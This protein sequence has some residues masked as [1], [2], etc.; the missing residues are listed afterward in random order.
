M[1]T[2]A[3]DA[4][5]ALTAK[6]FAATITSAALDRDGEVV[7]PQGM[8]ATS[9]ERNPILLWNH[10]SNYPVGKCTGLKRESYGI[11]GE[12]EF[13]QRPDN[14][15]GQWFPAFAASLV[16][17]GIV[18]G[19]S[20]G[21]MNEQGGTRRATPQDKKQFGDSVHTVFSKW[22]LMEISL[23]PVQSNPDALVTAIRKGKV[24]STDATRWLG[25]KATERHR[26][27][28]FLPAAKP[29]SVAKNASIDYNAIVRREIARARGALR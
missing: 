22:S 8:N 4:Q 19:V 11:V 21:Y 9:Y 26:V 2:K 3:V 15:D 27:E 16:A 1:K 13:A 14:W 18:R 6:G 25:Y 7:I 17:Q 20:I 23:A 5:F 28:I 24:S 10:D 12:F 29:A